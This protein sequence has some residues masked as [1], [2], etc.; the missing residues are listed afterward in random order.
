MAVVEGSAGVG[1]NA[2]RPLSSRPRVEGILGQQARPSAEFPAQES[3][4]TTLP[5]DEVS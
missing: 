5:I 4:A 1:A 3:W 2:K